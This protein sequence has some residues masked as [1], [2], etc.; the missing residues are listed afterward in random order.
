MRFYSSVQANSEPKYVQVQTFLVNVSLICIA[1]K[2]MCIVHAWYAST[3]AV[4]KGV[5]V[6]SQLS[7]LH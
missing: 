7:R 4:T 2:C 6:E 5:Y 1:Y 3:E